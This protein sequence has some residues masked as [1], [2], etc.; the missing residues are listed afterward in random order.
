MDWR[1]RLKRGF[2]LIEMA[3]VLTVIGII[4]SGGLLAVAPVLESSKGNETNAKLDRIEQALTLY[5]IRYGCLPC[6]AEPG[7]ASGTANAGQSHGAAYYSSGCTTACDATTVATQGIVPWVTLGLSEEEGRDGYGYRI[8]Y[9]VTAAL[10]AT[11]GMVRTPPATY[12]AGTL[13]VAVSAANDATAIATRTKV[14]STAAYV[15]IS[16]GVD[17]SLAWNVAGKQLPDPNSGPDQTENSNGTPF[18]QDTPVK[19]AGTYTYFDDIVRFRTAPMIIQ[20]CG[21][22]A[23]GNPA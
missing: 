17:H 22:N 11:N 16:H 19:N 13:A 18:V 8:D 3:I 10:V 14:S 2:S 6:P 21:T 4:L 9:A 20:L 7:I 12:P 23:C 1:R 15:L 5:V